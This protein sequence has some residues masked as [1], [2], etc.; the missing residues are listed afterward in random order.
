MDNSSAKIKKILITGGNSRFGV[1]LKKSFYG[2][3]IFYKNK[4]E[5]NILNINSI[6]KNLHKHKIDI[7]IHLA[8][9]SRPMAIHEK[10][11]FSSIDINIIGTAN[12]VKA[13]AEKN[14]KLIY[15]STSYVYQGKKGGYKE[16]DPI[17]PI[18]NYAWSKL[19]GESSV[20]LYKNSLILRLAM[21]EYPFIHPV[22]YTNAKNNFIYR[23]EVIKILPKLL[24]KKGV[25]N[26]GGKHST[27][28]YKFAKKSNPL[29]K[30]IKLKN[31]NNFPKDTSINIKKLKEILKKK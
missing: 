19:G 21:T 9:L 30:P 8:A 1:E 31:F 5:L 23:N 18:N 6:R 2:P 27:S 14:I 3:N 15:F 17:L 26:V 10:D 16:T 29:V 13:C 22:A 7:V 11:I 28:I 12:I 20:H 4:K 25:L 24:N